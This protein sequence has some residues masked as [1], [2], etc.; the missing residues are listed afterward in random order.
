[1]AHNGQLE[2]MAHNGGGSGPLMSSSSSG[3]AASTAN[4]SVDFSKP[5]ATTLTFEAHQSVSSDSSV[6]CSRNMSIDRMTSNTG[7]T[8]GTHHT[9]LRVGSRSKV[10]ALMTPPPSDAATLRRQVESLQ[11]DLEAHIESEQRLQAIN[12]QLRDRCVSS[13]KHRSSRNK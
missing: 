12:Q 8:S 4:K 11:L 6:S 1:M 2:E 10:E 3:K 7:S 9:L 13:S 5:L